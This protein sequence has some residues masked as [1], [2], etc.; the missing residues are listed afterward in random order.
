MHLS[1][2]AI[3]DGTLAR[4]WDAEERLDEGFLA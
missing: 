1:L 3:A 2:E 4:R